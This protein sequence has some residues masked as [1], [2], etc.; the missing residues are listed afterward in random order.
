[1]KIYAIEILSHENAEFDREKAKQ[2]V[3]RLSGA[4]PTHEYALMADEIKKLLM[5]FMEEET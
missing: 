5:K 4:Y 1:M 3:E 2:I